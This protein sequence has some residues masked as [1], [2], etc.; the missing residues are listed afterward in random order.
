MNT[1]TYTFT[2]IMAIILSAM[3][4][5]GLAIMPVS[6]TARPSKV[7]GVKVATKYQARLATFSN[8]SN[9][10]IAP[11]TVQW[12]KAKYA[13]KYQ[14]KYKQTGTKTWKYKTTKNRKLKIIDLN[15][16]SNNLK[17]NT[18]YSVRVRALR[19]SRKG[20][21]S[22]TIKFKTNPIVHAKPAKVTGVAVAE[23]YDPVV[24]PAMSTSYT[25]Y[26]APVK[27]EWNASRNA[28]KYELAFTNGKT[29]WRYMTTTGTSL[30]VKD[31]ENADNNLRVYAKY[32]FKVRAINGNTVG[33]WSDEITTYTKPIAFEIDFPD[34]S[35][36]LSVSK[37]GFGSITLSWNVKM[38][39]NKEVTDYSRI[40]YNI[41]G[42][43]NDGEDWSLITQVSADTRSFVQRYCEQN[44]EYSF[45]VVPV[46]NESYKTFEVEGKPS[47]VVK[48]QVNKIDGLNIKT[49]Y[50]DKNTE[51]LWNR[52]YNIRGL[53]LHSSREKRSAEE[54]IEFYNSEPDG[55]HAGS[56]H[57]FVDNVTGDIYK[58]LDWDVRAGHIGP[59]GNNKYL[60]VEICESPFVKYDGS[61]KIESTNAAINGAP[62][63]T[64]EE[65]HER[66]AR[67]SAK[68]TYKASVKLFAYLCD[69]Y[70]FNPDKKGV[71]ISSNEWRYVYGETNAAFGPT[72]YWY[73]LGMPYTMDG[74]RKEVKRLLNK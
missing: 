64:I 62:V 56:L 65:G 50:I 38:P 2:R 52:S 35:E 51:Y 15:K 66:E 46:D 27:I 68:I 54:L 48:T 30:V 25:D 32:S 7:K 16:P 59:A 10:Y 28:Q 36:A 57:A 18:K 33:D 4:V 12:K 3:L 17:P 72:H 20:S 47:N 21:W 67:E 70:G 61:K 69:Y 5:I 73:Q 44:L 31:F 11:V 40:K 9:G 29:D 45:K 49:S 23:R 53:M 55:I 6:A 42:S 37:R 14:V 60:A 74:F 8:D 43:I 71:V 39:S 13:K 34:M 58:A 63:L 26:C 41:Y 22:K 1:K 19:G 24:N